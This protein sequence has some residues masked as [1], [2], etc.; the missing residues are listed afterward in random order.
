MCGC[1][2]RTLPGAVTTTQLSG[3]DP[4]LRSTTVTAMAPVALH[5]RVTG[6]SA[7]PVVF[8]GG[9]LGSTHR[10]WDELVADLGA[11]HRVVAFDIR[12]HGFSPSAVGALTV[13]DL[14]SDV[15]ALANL[16]GVHTFHFVGLSLGGAIGEQ[17]ALDSPGRLTSLTLACTAPRFGDASTWLERAATVRAEGMTRMREPT[18]GRWFTDE[19]RLTRPE[20]VTSILDELVATDPESYATLCEAVGGF[21]ARDRLAEITAPTRVITA[22]GDPVC[23]PEVTKLLHDGIAGADSRLLGGSA[24]LANICRPAEFGAA[25]REHLMAHGG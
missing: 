18:G 11:D 2:G 13:A 23:P 21:D 16:L 6:P 4:R 3:H 25:V 10:M 1:H 8:L 5:H 22:D 20:R 17:L 24:H 9:S 14:A 12:G 15:V 19:A 7:A